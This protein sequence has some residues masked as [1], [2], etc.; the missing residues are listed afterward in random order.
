[1]KS[2][3]LTPL[4]LHMLYTKRWQI[5]TV[6]Y[7]AFIVADLL[8]NAWQI[9]RKKLKHIK[10]SYLYKYVLIEQLLQEWKETA[11]I[12]VIKNLDYFLVA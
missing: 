4:K 2:K 9:T 1:M 7:F 11:S 12:E 3:K 8:F 6:R 5:F 10:E